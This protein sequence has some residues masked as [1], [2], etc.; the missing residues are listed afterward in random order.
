M[1]MAPKTI[2]VSC[3]LLR[4]HDNDTIQFWQLFQTG[5]S[6]NQSIN[7]FNPT[8]AQYYS[9][10]GFFTVFY[11]ITHF[12]SPGTSGGMERNIVSDP[13]LGCCLEHWLFA[14]VGQTVRNLV[15]EAASPVEVSSPW[16]G[17]LVIGPGAVCLISS[18]FRMRLI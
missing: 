14:C 5:H 16:D 6:I 8:L 3:L 13:L 18:S 11:I 1:I 17:K 12:W 2:L 15:V 10:S 4:C 9:S 7:L